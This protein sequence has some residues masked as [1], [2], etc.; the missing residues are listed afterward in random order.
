MSRCTQKGRTGDLR[1]GEAKMSC[2]SSPWRNPVN[3]K[4]VEKCFPELHVKRLTDLVGKM[5]TLKFNL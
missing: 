3:G 1:T 4:N 5:L 2:F